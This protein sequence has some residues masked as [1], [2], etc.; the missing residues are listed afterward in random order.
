[1]PLCQGCQRELHLAKERCVPCQVKTYE[2]YAGP[3]VH[4]LLPHMVPPQQLAALR[5]D[6]GAIQSL[7]PPPHFESARLQLKSTML[8]EV[9]A[10]NKHMHVRLPPGW[11]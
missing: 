7:R 2:R 6:L 10:T 9:G 5:R 8:K 3:I 11:K 1:M 4:A